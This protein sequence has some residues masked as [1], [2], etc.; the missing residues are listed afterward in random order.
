VATKKSPLQRNRARRKKSP[1]RVG[2][3][4]GAD[5]VPRGRDFAGGMVS[6]IDQAACTAAEARRRFQA[7]NPAMATPAAARPNVEGSGTAA[8]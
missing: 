1:G 4:A 2:D 6:R 3:P 8:V 7:P 5:K